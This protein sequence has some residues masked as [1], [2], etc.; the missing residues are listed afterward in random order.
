MATTRALV[1]TV[2]LAIALH[3]QAPPDWRRI[4]NSVVDEML[5]GPASGPVD[6][7]WYSPD[8][9][10]LFL[11]TASGRAYQTS[12]F[13]NWQP[14]AVTTPPAPVLAAVPLTLPENG[15]QPRTR[16]TQVSRFYAF[17]DFVYR[18]DDGGSSWNNL[19]GFR[20]RSMIGPAMRDLA[21]SPANEDEITVADA[22]GVFRSLDGGKSWSS[23]NQDLP[24]LPAMRLM[25]LP[26]GGQG[27]RLALTTNQVVEWRPGERQTWRLS[28]NSAL[29]TELALR[30][31]LTTTAPM[32]ALTI[33]GDFVYTGTADGR[34]AVSSDGA[35][36]WQTFSVGGPVA[37]FWVDPQNPR[38]A[39][40]ALGSLPGGQG[41]QVAPMHVVHT[42]NGGAFWDDFTAN[43]PDVAAH[44]VAADPSSGAVYVATDR[45]VYYTR[46]DLQSLGVTQ[47]WT[48][49]GGLPA[50]AAMDVSLDSQANQLWVAVDGFGVYSALA[51]H[52]LGDPRVVS[53]ADF[54]AR[55]AAPGSLVS[56]LGARVAS[57]R[58]GDLSLPVLAAND[59]ESQIQIP[60]EA[61]GAALSL[62]IDV[63]K[64]R[65]T[66]PPMR[67]DSAS[68]AIFV[69][70]DGSPML[71]DAANG[72][73][74][75][76][77]TPA[78]SGARIQILATGLGRV[79]PDWP[80]GLAAPLA[81]PPQVAATVQAFLD[82]E[83]LA[84]TQATL[85]AGYIGF[86][87][88]EVEIP[89]IVNYGPAELYIQA[90]GQPSNRVRVY[91]EP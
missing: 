9:S 4:G 45:G 55:A 68:P 53:A 77:M 49:L 52:R 61:G 57:A 83:P 48:A 7:V 18:S 64:G 22:V 91:I 81:N 3:A 80:T 37:R 2:L 65:V 85:A 29:S 13:E 21:V 38:V 12:D 10:T 42:I 35:R 44:G 27:V 88:V 56:I 54:V 31:A 51:P 5:A 70:R 40:A 28:D 90:D 59:S 74:L 75:D 39:L 60:F 67:I 89:K 76:A 87:L 14:L 79:K 71:L 30:R 43:L 23:L 69:E 63:A 50:T 24:N 25:G 86:Y 66:L 8:G 19:T 33:S 17:A 6:R 36:S 47:P 62:A 73:M 78:H 72:V 84:V 11:L 26:A 20:S 32:T 46:A 82:R 1:A 58:A 15:A 41:S 16:P 34:I